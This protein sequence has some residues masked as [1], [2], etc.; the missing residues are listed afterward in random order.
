M[1]IPLSSFS[2]S[3]GSAVAEAG[4]A[5]NKRKSLRS[6]SLRDARSLWAM[7]KS[8]LGSFATGARTS[9]LDVRSASLSR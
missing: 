9:S 1:A 3:G 4:E 6:S 7:V 5:R 2:S 8:N